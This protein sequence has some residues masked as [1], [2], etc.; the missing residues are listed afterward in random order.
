MKNIKYFASVL[1]LSLFVACLMPSVIELPEQANV[2][3]AASVKINRKNATLVKGKTVQ[4]KISGTKKKISW[5]SSNK[6]VATVNAKGKVT[7]KKKGTATITAKLGKKKFSC[8]IKVENPKINQAYAFVKEGDSLTLKVTGTTQTINWSSDKTSVA[9]V[10]SKGVVSAKNAGSAI[11]T[12]KVGG[13]SLKCTVTVENASPKGGTRT[14]PLS[15]YAAYTTDIYAYSTY[16]G[17]FTIQLLDYKDGEAAKKYVMKNKD[18]PRPTSKQEYIYMKFKIKYISGSEEICGADVIWY[19]SDLY[20]TA[21][22]KRINYLDSAYNFDDVEDLDEI[23][24]YP[25]GSAV[26]SKALLISA[27]NSPVTYRVQT[28][29]DNSKE[30]PIYTWFTSKK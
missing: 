30:K 4:L 18:N 21:A 7:G 20:N 29:Y 5:S 11:I 28:G 10:S 12:A 13:I 19:Y 25:G 24:L 17:K 22:N 6:S 9:T 1:F 8:K 27:G 26:C 23:Y 15:A 2:V 16:L 14:N 3:H